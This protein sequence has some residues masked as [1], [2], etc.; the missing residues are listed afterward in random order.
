MAAFWTVVL[1]NNSGST[2]VLEEFGIEIANTT[3]I[4]LSDYF[5]YSDISDSKE[6]DDLLSAGTLVLNDGTSDLNAVDA[7]NY[8]KRDNIHND[9]ETHYTKTELNTS[10]G[11]SVV[12]WDNIINAPSF[13]SPTWIK[14]VLFM[15]ESI[16]GTE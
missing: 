3:Q 8:V 7:V 12:H 14:P 13:G 9:L 2:V 16:W 1:K 10:G 4:V 6:L 11:G 5:D 15:V